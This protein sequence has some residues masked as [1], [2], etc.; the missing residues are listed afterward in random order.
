MGYNVINNKVN[1]M[2][3]NKSDKKIKKMHS[4]WLYCDQCGKKLA[5]QLPNGVIEFAYGLNKWDKN[6]EPKVQIKIW[7][8]VQIK[9]LN[10]E[11]SA[12]VTFSVLPTITEKSVE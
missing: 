11:C 5:R 10:N 6:S 3:N 1:I 4:I 9:C 2:E 12:L 7:G 8:S